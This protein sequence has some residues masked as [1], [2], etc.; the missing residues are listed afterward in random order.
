[1][2]HTSIDPAAVRPADRRAFLRTAIAGAGTLAAMRTAFADGPLQASPTPSGATAAAAAPIRLCHLTDIH[3]Q[4]ERHAE[5]GM[6]AAF[7]RAQELK[8][9]LIITGGDGVMDAFAT[10]HGRSEELRKLFQA[11]L[12][13]ECSAPVHHV[14]GNHDIFGWNRKASES[15]GTEADWGKRFACDLYGNARTWYSFD[16]GAW[17][18]ICLDSVQPKGDAY[19]AYLD[20]EQFEWLGKTIAAT[21]EGMPIC[22]ISHIPILSLTTL[23]FGKPRGRDKVG[24]DV[25]IDNA[26]MHTDGTLLHDLFKRSGKVKLCL[27]GHIHLLDHCVLDGVAY[28]CDGAVSGNWWK[29]RLQGVPEGFGCLELR[30][31]GTFGHRYEAY[32]WQ[33]S[34]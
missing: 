22:V 19:T 2:T 5:A 21:P 33:A 32:G 8:P 29:G 26:E 12:K 15:A 9:D 4:P 20:E 10:K 11:T 28:I 3:V 23:T 14:T 34:E 17:R 16:H 27:S 18:F 24:T 13:R 30:P 25:V 1:M 7:R 31:D 6:A